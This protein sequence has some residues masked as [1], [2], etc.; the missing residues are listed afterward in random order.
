MPDVELRGGLRVAGARGGGGKDVLDLR[1]PVPE[2]SVGDGRQGTSLL[3]GAG[4]VT[5][6]VFLS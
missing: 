6:S 5:G 4:R 1:D 2:G 3:V